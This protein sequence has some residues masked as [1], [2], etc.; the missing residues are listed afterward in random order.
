MMRWPD[1][2]VGERYVPLTGRNEGKIGVATMQT[3]SA[4]GHKWVTLVFEDGQTEKIRTK[5]VDAL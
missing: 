1:V 4:F 2:V 3:E 5:L